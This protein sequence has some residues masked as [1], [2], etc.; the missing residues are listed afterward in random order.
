MLFLMVSESSESITNKDNRLVS[1]WK[2]DM[3]VIDMNLSQL[4]PLLSDVQH[5]IA[6]LKNLK[7][8]L[9]SF[10]GFLL[11]YD[12][13]HHVLD[14]KRHVRSLDLAYREQIFELL[15]LEYLCNN[16][17][18]GIRQAFES[19]RVMQRSHVDPSILNRIFDYL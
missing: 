5:N 4:N 11:N 12:E 2:K 9:R 14:I 8:V 13:V 1:R 7:Q 16:R 18:A 10:D 3:K 15:H 19:W 6:N 17:K